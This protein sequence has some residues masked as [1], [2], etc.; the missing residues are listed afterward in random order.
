MTRVP[1]GFVAMTVLGLLA[2]SGPSGVA[3]QAPKSA[4]RAA[5]PSAPKRTQQTYV[6]G[7]GDT[8]PRIAQ[9]LGVTV[10][11]LRRWNG[12]KVE[13]VSAGRRLKYFGAAAHPESIG[14][15]SSGSL[16]GGARLSFDGPGWTMSR[17]RTRV[18]GTPETV[19]YVTGCMKAYRKAY[20][21]GPAVNIGDL[22]G[23]D[24]G[25]AEPHV[26]HQSG[27]DVD[28]G[29]LTRPPQSPGRFDREATGESSLD[30]DKQWFL[31]KWF[32]DYTPVGAIFMDWGVVGALKA[33]VEKVYKKN[34]KL[35]RT[36]LAR[37]PSSVSGTLKADSDHRTHM[38]VRF[39]CPR[40]NRRC[41][42]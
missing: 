27:R 19:R 31:V 4:A 15:P 6:V 33:H 13:R 41:I 14:R 10:A 23:H 7:R 40:G 34:G 3:A 12:L 2:A 21:K 24:G 30:V 17:D 18:F 42:E 20:K 8:L 5:A 36:Y 11:E 29:F 28:I 1:P 25:P 35:R 37:F 22:S 9:A 26:S 32:L 39:K 16:R 38:H